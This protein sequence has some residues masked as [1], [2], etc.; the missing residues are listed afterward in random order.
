MKESCP[1]QNWTSV[2]S[3][4]CS[5]PVNFHCLKDEYG[6]IGW[7]CSE[8]VWVEKDRCPVF[9]VGAKKLDTTSCSQTRCP[10]YNY[11]SNDID[12]E[13]ACRYIMDTESSTTPFTTMTT[14]TNKNNFGVIIT[15]TMLTLVT[16]V[17]VTSILFFKCIRKSSKKNDFRKED[18]EHLLQSSAT[19]TLPKVKEQTNSFDQAK[20]FLIQKGMVAITGVQ[21]SGKTFLAKSL[22][23]SLQKDGKIKD[24]VLICSLNQLHWGPSEEIDIYI[25]DDIFYEL[26]LYEK[27]KETLKALNE[28]LDRAGNIKLII[29]IPSYTWVNH[30]YEFEAKFLKVFV[31]LE[32][33]E[34]NEKITIL[35]SIK[36]QH[37]LTNDQSKKLNELQ[38][39]DLLVTSL[40]CIGFP[41]LVSWMCK[42]PSL[43]KLEK[44][45]NHPLET[46]R[47]EILSIKN[48]TMVEEKGRFLILSY[49]C[50]KDG[51]MNVKNVDIEIFNYLKKKYV[52]AFEDKDLAKYCE[53]MVGYYLVT[54]EDGC[55][56][57]DLNIMKK[58][59][60]V[61]L[62]KDSIPFVKEHCKNDYFKYVIN[63]EDPCPRN[64]ETWYMECFTII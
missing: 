43:E 30:C 26:Q 55:Y 4:R 17:F 53:G 46:M 8:P 11:R 41:A 29:T 15:L 51:K 27:F 59:V 6:R 61:S 34:L 16:I 1:Y 33:R 44:C 25:I 23:N 40:E 20:H 52:P 10:L 13:Y 42:Q 31:D 47:D 49:M 39:I 28:F 54:N 35:K 37:D 57:F 64:V 58:I 36:A 38:Q 5:N 63:K 7:V 18:S 45:L 2:A 24:S 19:K 21:G 60:F 3:E 48:A 22:V 9:N 56:E 14:E 62:A 12:V 32:K 50:L